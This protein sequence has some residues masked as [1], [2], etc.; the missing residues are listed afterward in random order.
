MMRYFPR[1]PN[2]WTIFLAMLVSASLCVQ[3]VLAQDQQA[4]PPNYA[5]DQLDK[6]VARIALYPDPLLAQI[7]TASTFPDQIPDAA[8][9]SDDHHYLSGQDLANAITNDQLSWDPSV[10]ALLPFPSVLDMMASDMDWTTDLGNAV[11]A[12]RP[13][14]M[15]AVQRERHKAKEY[16]YLR[17]NAQIVVS[18]GA[19][20]DI[21]PVDPGYIVVPA[22]DPLIVFAPPRPGFFIGGA[23]VF[24]F[25]VGIGG[26]FGPWG[27]GSSRI[28]W[29]DHAFF[30]NNARW[31]RTWGNRGSYVHPYPGLHRYGPGARVEH[32]AL[33][34]RS[35]RER[36]AARSGHRMREE[37]HPGRPHGRPR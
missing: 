19:Y 14:V 22:Y 10:Q 31:G 23:I 5:P 7:L 15:D 12:Q 30:I 21:M 3:P 13:D 8:K 32:H 29:A 33:I 28:I 1:R 37:H 36:A 20:I 34:G 9:W 2:I 26:W 24:G 27:W 17:T 11:L 18:G 16:G 4:P 35:V 6:M 25:G